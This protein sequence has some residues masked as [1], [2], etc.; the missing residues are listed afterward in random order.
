MSLSAYLCDDVNGCLVQLV[1]EMHI[2][3]AICTSTKVLNQQVGACVELTNTSLQVAVEVNIFIDYR[4]YRLLPSKSR[5][6][7]T[8]CTLC[9]L[10][11]IMLSIGQKC[12][13]KI[14]RGPLSSCTH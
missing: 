4:F 3:L 13:W 10:Y 14:S 6:T 1:Q 8:N 7:V 12:I 11:L 5:I 2:L 9:Q